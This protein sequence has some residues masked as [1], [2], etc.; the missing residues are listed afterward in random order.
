MIANF[1]L[2]SEM[3]TKS[4]GENRFSGDRRGLLEEW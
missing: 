1:L 4:G 3:E 2:E